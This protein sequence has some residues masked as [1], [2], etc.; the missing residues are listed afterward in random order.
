MVA[1]TSEQFLTVAEV[2]QQLR[3]SDEAVRVWLRKGDLRGVSLGRKA[4]WR[5]RPSE[6]DRFIR[7][8]DS[9]DE[10]EADTGRPEGN[11]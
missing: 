2:A 8:R 5:I 3:V 9:T 1:M 4:G 10:S 11:E 6:L 7:A